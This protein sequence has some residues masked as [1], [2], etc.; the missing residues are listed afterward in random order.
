MLLRGHEQRIAPGAQLMMMG[1]AQAYA[2]AV[3]GEVS[4]AI[5]WCDARS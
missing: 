3:A 5:T 2:A 1:E 4:R